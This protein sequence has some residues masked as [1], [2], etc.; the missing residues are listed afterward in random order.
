M[1][2]TRIAV[3]IA[4]VLLAGGLYGATWDAKQ[5]KYIISGEEAAFYDAYTCTGKPA[6]VMVR[7]Q[8]QSN[9][10]L[11]YPPE[12]GTWNDRISCIQTAE[13]ASVRVCTNASLGGSCKDISGGQT[14]SLSGDSTYDNKISSIRKPAQVSGR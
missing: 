5:N 7:N 2:T 11:L 12:G 8:Y 14:V 4:F 6:L 3:I 10:A 9:L 1:R 13:N